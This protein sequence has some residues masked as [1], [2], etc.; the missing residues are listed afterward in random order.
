MPVTI[1]VSSLRRLFIKS[2]IN[3]EKLDSLLGEGKVDREGY[4]YITKG[5]E[6]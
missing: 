1:L 4:E 5:D 6:K 2:E 3:K